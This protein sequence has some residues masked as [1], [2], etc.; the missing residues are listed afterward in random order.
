MVV[1]GGRSRGARE[2]KGDE[3]MGKGRV[4][5][6]EMEEGEGKGRIGEV[7]ERGKEGETDRGAKERK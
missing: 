1:G 6:E 5:G 2:R 4:R 3:E 7:G